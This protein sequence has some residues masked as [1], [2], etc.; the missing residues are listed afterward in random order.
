MIG[1]LTSLYRDA[2]YF[3]KTSAKLRSLILREF[4]FL[5][6]YTPITNA[7]IT[8]LFP[9]SSSKPFDKQNL[10]YQSPFDMQAKVVKNGLKPLAGL[11]SEEVASRGSGSIAVVFGG[12]KGLGRA[13][14]N[15]LNTLGAEKVVVVGRS[16]KSPLAYGM[17]LVKADMSSMK[18][19]AKLL[20]ANQ[21][22]KETIGVADH[23]IFT[24]GI[25]TKKVREETSEGIEIDLAVSYLSRLVLVEELAN[26]K[27]SGELK[28]D[29]KVWVMGFPGVK[30]VPY[31]L[32]DLNAEKSYKAFPQHMYTVIGNECIVHKYKE[33][34]DMFGL[35]PGIIATDIRSN[36]LGNGYKRKI[37]ES[38]VSLV[39]ISPQKY[40]ER[41]ARLI[42]SP[43]LDGKSGL[44]FNQAGRE[45]HRNP[46]CSDE[47]V[48]EYIKQS[49]SLLDKVLV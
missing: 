45:V 49:K 1:V 32:N 21:V 3:H 11:T 35:N 26:M 39:N 40:G 43:Q 13:I 25:M 9:L 16:L 7:R 15:S 14:A 33:E 28:K 6:P 12:T 48:E 18:A 4:T 17:E 24:V 5:E 27:K 23:I 22:L 44:L 10:S 8:P 47:N 42:L 31:D 2:L 30:N 34:L 46:W 29:V 20:E 36:Y 41:T 19:C 37:L 38:V